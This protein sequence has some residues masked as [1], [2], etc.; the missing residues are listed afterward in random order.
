MKLYDKSIGE[1][2]ISIGD[3]AFSPHPLS[4]MGIEFAS[5][6]ATSAF[7]AI[8]QGL[9]VRAQSNYQGWINDQVDLQRKFKDFYY[10]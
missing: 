8:K 10:F 7:L 3:A 2:W 1:R 4:G 9:D 6:S 5:E